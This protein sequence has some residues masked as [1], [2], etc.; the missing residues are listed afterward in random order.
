[1]EEK[2]A[3]GI[4]ITFNVKCNILRTWVHVVYLQK[5]LNPRFL[6]DSWLILTHY[7]CKA[8][9]KVFVNLQ[10]LQGFLWV[11]CDMGTAPLS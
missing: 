1:M 9:Q 7:S 3:K 6:I 5:T 2:A 8:V 11:F 4:F 10:H